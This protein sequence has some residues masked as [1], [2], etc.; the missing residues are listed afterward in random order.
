MFVD[1]NSVQNPTAGATIQAAWGDQVRNDLMALIGKPRVRVY[2]TTN[3]AISDSSRTNVGFDD[4]NVDSHGMHS[5]VTNNDRL[6]VPADWDGWWLV[7]CNIGW[8]GNVT[9]TRRAEIWINDAI[10]IAESEIPPNLSS[11]ECVQNLSTFFGGAAGDYYTVRVYQTSGGSLQI[12]SAGYL[13]TFW[14][15]FQNS[16]DVG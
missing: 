8:E 13:P 14:A 16:D 10:M 2:R 5:N 12:P 3:Q 7:G 11:G 9:G 6:T 4:E 1:P 15:S